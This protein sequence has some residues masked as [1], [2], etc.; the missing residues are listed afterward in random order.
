MKNKVV[1]FFFF[2]KNENKILVFLVLGELCMIWIKI[3]CGMYI[4]NV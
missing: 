4:I 3:I 1:F 2:Y